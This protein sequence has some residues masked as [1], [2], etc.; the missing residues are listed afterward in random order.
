MSEDELKPLDA[1]PLNTIRVESAISRFPFHRLAKQGTISIDLQEQDEHGETTLSWKVAFSSTHGQPGPLAYKLDTI[2]INR[3]IEEARPRVPKLIK[4]G[5]LSE[6]CQE[7]GLSDSGKNR[8]DIK[9]ALFQNA[10]AGI[11]PQISYKQAD[12]SEATLE[13]AFTRYSVILTGKTLPDGRKADG[14]YI[15]LNDIFMQVLRGARTRPLDYEYLKILTPA[16]QRFYELLSFRMYA[17][18]KHDRPRAKLTYSE[19]C[20]YAPQTRHDTWK[21]VRYQMKRIHTVHQQNGYIADVEFQEITDSS[22]KPDWIMLYKPGAKARAEFRAVEKKGGQRILEVEPFDND[23]P[24]LNFMLP[25]AE[26]SAIESELTK[27]GVA[28]KTAADLAARHPAEFIA[29]KIEHFDYLVGKGDKKVSKSPSGYLF[30]SIND[31]YSE[32]KGFGVVEAAKITAR[33]TSERQRQMRE[34]ETKDKEERR[35]IKE[36][37]KR[38][39]PEGLAKLEAEAVARADD[40]TRQSL[41]DCPDRNLRRMLTAS[42][43]DGLILELLQKEAEPA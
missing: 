21:L 19:L 9:K 3:R 18:L 13:T 2:I 39:T 31:D 35:A 27:R 36:F 38:L 23:P 25:P 42:L 41:A 5:S 34:K 6:I 14:V 11:Q 24:A 17:T 26:P 29:K 8:S 15:I 1:S 12:G 33:E 30:M 43:C 7:L 16:S 40:I 4:L 22:G 37:R 10:F 32:P 20:N 28:A